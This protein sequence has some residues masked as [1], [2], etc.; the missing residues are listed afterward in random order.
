VNVIAIDEAHH[1]P[2]KARKA[3]SDSIHNKTLS[4]HFGA[5]NW[6]IEN[7][8][9]ADLWFNDAKYKELEEEL[10]SFLPEENEEKTIRI[11]KFDDELIEVVNKIRT[12]LASDAAELK[13]ASDKD[14]H[15]MSDY[16][17][18]RELSNDFKSVFLNND[19]NWIKTYTQRKNSVNVD[20]I[21]L[22]VGPLLANM[23][24]SKSVIMTSATLRS[25]NSFD[26]YK[27]Q[28]KQPLAKTYSYPS[29]FCKKHVAIYIPPEPIDPNDKQNYHKKLTDY[30][31]TIHKKMHGRSIFL[32]TNKEDLEACEKLIPQDIR[33]Q[34]YVQSH[35]SEIPQMVKALQT[36]NNIS[37]VG[38]S[39]LWEGI[40]VS[41]KA[42]SCVCVMRMPFMNP[43]DVVCSALKDKYKKEHNGSDYGFFDEYD[44]PQMLLKL[45][46]GIGRL[47]RHETDTGMICLL[48]NRFMNK[49]YRNRVIELLEDY[50]CYDNL[51]ETIEAI[52]N[53]NF[54]RFTR[55]GDLT[56]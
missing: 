39:T 18:V 10:F 56:S 37:L 1:F 47:I 26:F 11:D 33:K 43:D 36:E 25:G 29:P 34:F 49:K 40:D 48:D 41:G 51:D 28:I 13:D 14:P 20:A 8:L 55:I 23:F 19:D 44:L 31:A 12:C 7:V 52:P 42:L 17:R 21:P 32:F 45:K 35:T 5:L 22:D 2:D 38:L 3:L 53:I 50:D 9:H 16:K 15:L 6:K 24:A 46:Q 27:N 54:G 30:M 4:K